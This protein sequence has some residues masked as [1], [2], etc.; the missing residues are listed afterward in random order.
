MKKEEKDSIILYSKIIKCNLM[1]AFIRYCGSD[2][3]DWTMVV[4]YLQNCH[5]VQIHNPNGF[6]R[7]KLE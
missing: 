3:K 4:Y 6:V 1:T 5:G 7:F 2:K